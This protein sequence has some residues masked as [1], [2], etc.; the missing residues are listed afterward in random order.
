LKESKHRVKTLA[1]SLN[2]LHLGT[3]VEGNFSKLM[4]KLAFKERKKELEI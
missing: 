3:A 1:K 2:Y 4:I